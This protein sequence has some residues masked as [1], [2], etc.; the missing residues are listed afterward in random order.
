MRRVKL[1]GKREQPRISGKRAGCWVFCDWDSGHVFVLEKVTKETCSGLTL[2]F[3]SD[4][5]GGWCSVLFMSRRGV[6][7]LSLPGQLLNVGGILSSF[8][9]SL[10]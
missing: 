7:W 9:F 10:K 1:A 5:V 2:R 4:L 6:A 8:S 3:Q